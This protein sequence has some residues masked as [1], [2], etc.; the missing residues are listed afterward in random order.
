MFD[1]HQVELGWINLCCGWLDFT[2]WMNC[3]WL[4]PTTIQQRDQSAKIFLDLKHLGGGFHFKRKYLLISFENF[5]T[6]HVKHIIL[7]E[8]LYFSCKMYIHLK[9][10][11]YFK[12]KLSLNF[13]TFWMVKIINSV[14]Q[15][16]WA[17]VI[18]CENMFTFPEILI[19]SSYSLCISAHVKIKSIYFITFLRDK[20]IFSLF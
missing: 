2:S 14:F 7:W 13:M 6:F 16:V 18:S 4:N 9:T 11:L 20:I 17:N 19:R 12:W 15:F 10:S 3:R 1:R 5:F 8:D